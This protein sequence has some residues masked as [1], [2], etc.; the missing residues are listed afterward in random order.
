LNDSGLRISRKFPKGTVVIAI[1]GATIGVTGILE[2][3]A[4]FPDSIVGLESK[5]GVVIPEFLYWA[6]EYAKQAAL[7]EATQTTQPNIN[8][9]NLERLRI[10]IPSLHAQRYAV[11]YLDDL[12][13]KAD[14]LKKLQEETA[15][16]INA[17]LP[18][19]LARAFSGEL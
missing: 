12:Q 14:T 8:L 15:E 7:D 17:L 13:A 11:T 16:E 9:K 1:T 3:D 2:F 6:L 4:C 18:A 10:P 19:I 5:S